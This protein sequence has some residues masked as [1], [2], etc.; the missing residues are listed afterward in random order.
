M[1]LTIKRQAALDQRLVVHYARKSQC[2]GITCFA[3]C[4]PL[5]TASLL[6][7]KVNHS[8]R[9]DLCTVYGHIH[10]HFRFRNRI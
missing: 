3:P 9:L 4:P 10:Q 8:A 6:E 1:Q 7:K 5:V 2:L